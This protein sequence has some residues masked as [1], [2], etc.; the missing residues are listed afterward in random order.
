MQIIYER[1]SQQARVGVKTRSG[2][3]R[4]TSEGKSFLMS[5]KKRKGPCRAASNNVR[6]RHRYAKN[7]FDV[8]GLVLYNIKV[9]IF[10]SMGEW[11]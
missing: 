11:M 6:K 3:L 1:T 8:W 5:P 2:M 9:F 4:K 10:N 7:A